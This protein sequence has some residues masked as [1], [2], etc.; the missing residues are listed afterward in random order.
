MDPKE[1]EEGTVRLAD[2]RRPHTSPK[3][4]STAANKHVQNGSS[5]RRPPNGLVGTHVLNR[6]EPVGEGN[7]HSQSPTDRTPVRSSV[8]SI[9]VID[10]HSFTRECI[11]RWLQ[12]VGDGVDT[13][14]FGAYED[15]LQSARNLDLILY[16]AHERAAG[17]DNEHQRLA[18]LKE[19]LEVAPVIIL[20]AVDSPDSILDAFENGARGYIPTASTTLE[21]AR[22]IIRLV[23]A[24][25]TFVPPSSLPLRRIDRQGLHPRVITTDEFTPRQI[26]VLNHLKVGKANKAI[27]HALEMSESTV[28]VHIRNIM[29][30][31]KATN[32]TEVA[33]RAHSITTSEE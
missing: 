25:G 16:H 21:L 5:R 20:S 27:A 3:R 23:R 18:P 17:H 6:H 15:C 30:K 29:K 24:G 13:V 2:N 31:M 7:A 28:K 4:P 1:R 33:C 19:L 14:S 9:A 26:A 11:I 32:R 10:E 22:E 12:E 8:I